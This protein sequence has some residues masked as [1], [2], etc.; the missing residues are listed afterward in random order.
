MDIIESARRLGKDIQADERYKAFIKAQ[1]AAQNDEHIAAVSKQLE[2]IQAEFEKV[3]TENPENEEKLELLHSEYIELF[4]KVNGEPLMA[5]ALDARSNI[6]NMMNDIMQIIY[7]CLNGEDPDT[8]E[9]SAENL[10][11]MQNSIL[12]I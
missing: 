6:D 12:G 7:L 2:E 1:E 10:E 5:A 8:C 3:A 11:R 4:Q 9:L